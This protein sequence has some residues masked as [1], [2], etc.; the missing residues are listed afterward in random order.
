MGGYAYGSSGFRSAE[1]KNKPEIKTII[2]N[3][4]KVEIPKMTERDKEFDTEAGNDE[5]TNLHITMAGAGAVFLG[6]FSDKTEQEKDAETESASKYIDGTAKSRYILDK[7]KSSIENRT[8]LLELGNDRYSED[9]SDFIAKLMKNV[10]DEDKIFNNAEGLLSDTEKEIGDMAWYIVRK[11]A[12]S[13]SFNETFNKS[14]EELLGDLLKS[15]KESK[16]FLLEREI[17]EYV[18]KLFPNLD[19]AIK[20]IPKYGLFDRVT[21]AL[22]NITR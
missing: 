14:Q 1:H 17:K 2:I 6:A 10:K 18:V 16:M 11:I 20:E 21:S 19:D 12:N 7:L 8:F 13:Y 9:K 15:L 5:R 3:S 4:Q 22:K